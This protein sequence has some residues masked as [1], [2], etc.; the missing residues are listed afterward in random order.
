MQQ[1]VPVRHRLL[2]AASLVASVAYLPL[3][4]QAE[5]AA[6]EIPMP[7]VNEQVW[8]GVPP[9]QDA[10][11]DYAIRDA[12]VA[13]GPDAIWLLKHTVSL[14]DPFTEGR[15]PGSRGIDIAAEYI[16]FY[17]RR[18]GLEPLF[19]SGSTPD[20][21]GAEAGMALSYLQNFEVRGN[22]RT[23]H[24]ALRA[25]GREAEVGEHFQPLGFSANARAEGEMVFV[26]YAIESGPDGYSSF[27]DDD[28]LTGKIV[29]M[30]RFEP[31][32]EGGNSLW[33][34]G[35]G[36]SGAAGFQGK[37]QSV[38]NRG[39]AGVIIVNPPGVSDPR[40]RVLASPG[41]TGGGFGL[42]FPVVMV[43]PDFAEEFL[44]A[45][46]VGGRSLMELRRAADLGEVGT[47]PLGVDAELD[48]RLQRQM[49]PTDNVAAV[50]RGR[51]A[52]ADEYVVVGAHYDHLGPGEFGS[53]A[54][55]QRGTIH[56]GADDNASGTAGVLLAARHL[57][58]VY[59]RAP[60]DAD[61]RSVIFIAFSGEEMGLLGARHF[62][63]EPPVP[64]ESIV[65]MLNMDMIG[66]LNSG[67]ALT[68]NGS[69]T[70]L[71]WDPILDEASERHGIALRKNPAGSGAS[72]H[73]QFYRVGIPALH[74]FSG[75][76]AEYHTPA[77]T[78]D[79]LNYEG[80]A[81][82]TRMV[83]DV[84]YALATTSERLEFRQTQRQ[85]RPRVRLGVQLGDGGDEPGVLLGAIT[86]GS[87]AAEAG[88]LAGDRIVRIGDAQTLDAMALL[89]ALAGVNPGDTV[90]IFFVRDGEQRV[91][92]VTFPAR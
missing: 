22:I 34:T 19:E 53:R 79:T 6:R 65:A 17:L 75:L 32:D 81:R 2:I 55:E 42:E 54:P 77:D 80:A 90:S 64:V 92:E 82:I 16:E 31:M 76:T 43:T 39:A 84:A 74:F 29:V 63:D 73:A 35:R 13:A 62:V 83:A 45:E 7:P 36:W 66:R 70:A 18:E 25:G 61:L 3:S 15:V 12:I 20:P 78:F 33:S 24:A 44:P 88:M 21:G 27:G 30:L 11:Q 48:V 9:L 4:A 52:L 26:G 60:S 87:P 10:G 49:I 72:D 51:G 69:G 56:P 5:D 41:G 50:L 28:D 37:L 71:Q 58:E 91:T 38:G 8:Q 40:G 85:A 57:A 46:V 23:E 59:R 68:V 14:S 86:P 89:G 1:S 67:S 47:I